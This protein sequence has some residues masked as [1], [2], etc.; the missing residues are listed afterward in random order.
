MWRSHK[1]SS[2]CISVAGTDA[3][4]ASRGPSLEG[5]PFLPPLAP[6]ALPDFVATMAALTSAGELALSCPGRSPVF[7]ARP[8]PTILSPTTQ[9]S[10][11]DATASRIAGPLPQAAELRHSLAGSS[12]GFGRI[13]FTLYYGLVGSFSLLSTPSRDDAVTT[14]SRPGYGP[15][16]LRSPTSEGCAPPQRTRGRQ[17]LTVRCTEAWTG[18]SWLGGGG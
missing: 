9:T 8:F 5:S 1:P 10:P 4:G 16:R 14:S 6:S 11:C 13:V 12:V 17:C 3:E 15:S 18:L 2:A 7:T